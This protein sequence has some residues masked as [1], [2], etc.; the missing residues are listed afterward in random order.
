M[1][2][3]IAYAATDIDRETGTGSG[4]GTDSG[5]AITDWESDSMGSAS[6]AICISAAER[7]IVEDV[8]WFALDQVIK[9][10]AL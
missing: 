3:C 9:Y 5:T 2:G 7:D 1:L 8:Q 4:I 6:E 10:A